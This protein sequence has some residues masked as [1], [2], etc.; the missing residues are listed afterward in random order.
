MRVPFAGH[1]TARVFAFVDDITVFI[2]HRLDIKAVKKAV[3]E[4]EWIAGAR[5]KFDKSEGWRLGA[6]RGSGVTDPSASL[7]C[8]LGLTSNWSEIGQ[9]YKLR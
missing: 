7:G 4:Y 5:V 8:G 3:C 2:S 9:K 1:L 6:W